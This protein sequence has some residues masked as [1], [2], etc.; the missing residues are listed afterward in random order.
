[1]YTVLIYFNWL[2]HR[3]INIRFKYH[4]ILNVSKVHVIMKL[5]I[6]AC[7]KFVTK[8][9]S[10]LK[11]EKRLRMCNHEI[12]VYASFMSLYYVCV[13]FIFLCI[14]IFPIKRTSDLF[15]R[16]HVIASY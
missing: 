2:Q 4:L 14:Q 13:K 10:L 7:I 15:I 8:N 1:M 9:V 5:K 16:I 3:G 12:T 6:I 11:T